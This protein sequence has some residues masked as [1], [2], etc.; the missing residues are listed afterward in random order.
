M[1]AVEELALRIRSGNV[2]PTR[3][4]AILETRGVALGAADREEVLALCGGNP[5]LL[6]GFAFHAWER[7][8]QGERI[9]SE[10]IQAIGG[11]LVRDYLPQVSTILQDG[12]ML[13]KAVQVVVGPQWDVTTDDL[14]ALH[15]LGV[16]R[17]EQ[18]ELRGFSRTFED[19]LRL[20]G[21]EIDIWPLWRDTERALRDVLERHLDLVY[22]SDWPDRLV[23]ARPKLG[24]IIEDWRKNR[25]RE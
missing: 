5:Y 14:A 23:K 24:S 15:E 25:E 9:D 8:D 21:R 2:D 1:T 19:H 17:E 7:A 12:P 18:G 20:V 4:A 3:G 10:W 11:E 6:D 22:G 16:L 13:S